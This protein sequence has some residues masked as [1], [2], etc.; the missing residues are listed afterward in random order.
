MRS[1]L[2]RRDVRRMLFV[3]Y[4]EDGTL[5][6]QG[7]GNQILRL[8]QKSRAWM[9]NA[10]CRGLENAP[11]VPFFILAI[12][13]LSLLSTPL[14]AGLAVIFNNANWFLA[15]VV[16]GI[17]QV[18]AHVP[19]GHFYFEHPHWPEKLVAKI[20]VLDVGAG[21]AVR[22]QAGSANWLFESIHHRSLD[23]EAFTKDGSKSITV[24]HNKAARVRLSSSLSAYVARPII[25]RRANRASSFGGLAI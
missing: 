11:E 15:K 25:R 16:L 20:T 5:I 18:L 1:Y 22:L 19:G 24:L 4:P 10:L 12:A 6:R 2:A 13:L 7:G 3:R 14:L 17:V 9:Q 21:A 8:A 23:Y